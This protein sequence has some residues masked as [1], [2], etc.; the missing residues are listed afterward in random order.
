MISRTLGVLSARRNS[1][2]EKE[3][4]FTLIEL[5]VVIVII[6][7][8]AAIAIPVYLGVQNNAKNS[9]VQSDLTNAKTAVI[10]YETD[11]SVLPGVAPDTTAL[12]TA[13]SP[14]GLGTYGFTQSSN[15]TSIAYSGV[16]SATFFC[17][18]AVGVTGKDYYVT[19]S[20]GV[21]AGP[22]VPTGC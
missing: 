11:K 17:I 1:L 21:A 9:A 5:L 20:T 13:A 4:G 14:A 18:K 22:T 2:Q 16:P 12:S 19:D 8:L 7:I 3:K 6:G 15:T 10:A